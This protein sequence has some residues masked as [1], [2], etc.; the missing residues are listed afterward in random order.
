M[1]ELTQRQ[2]EVLSFIAGYINQHNYPP[3]IREIGDFFSISV[4]G[5]HDHVTAL[6][7][8]GVLKQEDKRSRTMELVGEGRTSLNRLVE[9]PLLGTVAAGVPILS[10]ENWD[11]AVQIND[12]LLKKNRKYFALKVRGDS[13]VGA[14]I[15]DGD[16]AVIEKQSIAKNGEIVVAVV[17]E[18]VTLKRFFRE[19]KR[20]KLQAENPGY[21]PIYSQNI[22]L[23]GRLA[24]IIR[25]Y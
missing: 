18:A 4:K 11:G 22:R 8:K 16:T 5:A 2:K 1:K 13:M 19:S 3:T 9:I 17:D 20:V 6:K 7:R 24:H 10:E 14:G 25:S 23:L 15:M 21:P 12:A